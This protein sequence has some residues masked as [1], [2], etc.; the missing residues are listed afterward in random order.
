MGVGGRWKFQMRHKQII[1]IKLHMI[2]DDQETGDHQAIIGNHV[3]DLGDQEYMFRKETDYQEAV[4]QKQINRRR[5]IR[6]QM[7]RNQ[8]TRTQMIMRQMIWR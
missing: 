7:V 1:R 4:D 2:V 8:M 6:R 3:K 5:I